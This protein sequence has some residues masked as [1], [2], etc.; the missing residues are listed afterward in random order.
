MLSF[1]TGSKAI[2]IGTSFSE[3]DPKNLPEIPQVLTNLTDFKE[4]LTNSS[5]VGLDPDDIEIVAN[6]DNSEEFL[7]K[8]KDVAS[9]AQDTLL[10]YYCGHGVY[11]D[12]LEPLY[13][14]T[15]GTTSEDKEINGVPISGVKNAIANSPASKRIFLLDCCY[16]GQAMEGAL[17]VVDGFE[18]HLDV[19]GTFAI[20]AVPRDKKAIAEPGS[21]NSVFFEHFKKA[22]TEGIDNGRNTLSMADLHRETEHSIRRTAKYPLPVKRVWEDGDKFEFCINQF[23]NA[24][25]TRQEVEKIV[26]ERLA[27]LG[28]VST[29]GLRRVVFP[30]LVGAGAIGAVVAAIGMVWISQLSLEHQALSGNVSGISDD[31]SSL[32]KTDEGQAQLMG[33]TNLGLAGIGKSVAN[34]L[35]TDEQQ[36]EHLTQLSDVVLKPDGQTE[37]SFFRVN[38][39]I[40]PGEYFPIDSNSPNPKNDPIEQIKRLLLPPEQ[41]QLTKLHRVD[42]DENK[43]AY[44]IEKTEHKIMYRAGYRLHVFLQPQTRNNYLDANYDFREHQVTY[45]LKVAGGKTKTFDPTSYN[46]MKQYFDFTTDACDFLAR[47]DEAWGYV[48][49]KLCFSGGGGE[50]PCGGQ[51]GVSQKMQFELKVTAVLEKSFEADKVCENED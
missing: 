35:G 33:A 18:S 41:S 46:E 25:F 22:I 12:A 30:A 19:D 38:T 11:G 16:A 39:D 1:Q 7:K 5:I 40:T 37:F 6:A 2:L 10:V 28:T 26:E 48:P 14:C 44:Y 15:T 47:K 49:I 17:D 32:S 34:L 36:G 23:H 50:N 27:G 42:V 4:I 3:N 8:L 13:F 45:G 20:G 29:S 51:T 21:R 24:S 9:E 31:V 43:A